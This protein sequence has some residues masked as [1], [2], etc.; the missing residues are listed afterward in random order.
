M[1]LHPPST[2]IRLSEMIVARLCHDLGSPLS[3]LTA[4]MPQAADPAAHAL[5]NET[6]GE[7]RLRHR[8]LCAAFGTAE[9]L[10]W[11]ELP[12]LLRGAPRAHSVAFALR[13]APAPLSAEV[14]RL[15]LAAALLG[16]EALPR[17]GEVELRAEAEGGF[18][19][20]PRGRDA[21]WPE[22]LLRLASGGSLDT[23]LREGPRH[24]LAAWV[25][26]LAG[27]AG[28]EAGFALPAGAG[29][30][31]LSLRAAG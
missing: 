17:G 14:A 7:I 29:L 19:L 28:M 11:A 26:R 9:E 12:A 30:P 6:V 25:W 24:V 13:G 10:S 15:L 2:D 4:V 8:L 5:L 1:T 3:T 20:L 31:A 16:A 27:S 23:A 22:A 18:T 21:A